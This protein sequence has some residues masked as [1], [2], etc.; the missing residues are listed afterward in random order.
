MHKKL[1]PTHYRPLCGGHWRAACGE[2][3]QA[4]FGGGPTEKAR[5]TGTS[6]A[7]YFTLKPSGAGDLFV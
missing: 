2:S 7:A 5:A 4:R 3:S 6:P 1:K